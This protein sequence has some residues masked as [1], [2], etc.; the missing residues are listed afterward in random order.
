MPILDYQCDKCG[1]KDEYIVSPSVPKAMLPPE[2]CPKC[3]EG[4]L[5]RLFSPKGIGFDV[6][7]GY[8]YQWGAK[9]WRL[10]HTLDEQSK[11]LNN[12]MSPY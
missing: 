11:I 6:P 1:F 3:N 8:S 2:V 12:Q 9:N 4:K 10:H 7:G 5:E